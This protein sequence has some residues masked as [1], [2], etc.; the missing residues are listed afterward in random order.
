MAG[1]RPVPELRLA[2]GGLVPF[3]T[4][5][6]PG[7][8]AAVVFCQG[9]PWRCTYCH[10]PHL[11]PRG[12]GAMAWSEVL[13]FLRRRQGLLDGVVFSGGEPTLQAGLPEALQMVKAL[14]YRIGL[15][16]GGMYPERLAAVLPFVDWVGIDVKAP[17]EDY[18]RITGVP[19][20][21]TPVQD[22]LALLLASGVDFET[23]TTVHPLLLSDDEAL[24][25]A[26]QLSARGVKRHVVQE[27]RTQGCQDARLTQTKTRA[28]PFSQLA[29]EVDK[30][31]SYKS[32][33]QAN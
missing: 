14:G 22:S 8:L 20:S 23:R 13:D 21:G 29:Q 30:L 25:I 10:N 18:A 4:I 11:L 31:F 27:F 33:P 3:T 12:Q 32:G 28:R 15:H 2:V 7:R 19:Q 9:C 17:F 24:D 5:D 26:R 16:T 6:F 1:A